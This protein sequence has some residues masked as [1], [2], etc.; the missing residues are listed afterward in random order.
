MK[1]RILFS[2]R[3]GQTREIAEY[4]ASELKELQDQHEDAIRAQGRANRELS[5]AKTDLTVAKERATSMAS[6]QAEL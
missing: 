6:R 1:T 3:E 4:L 2:S 5:D